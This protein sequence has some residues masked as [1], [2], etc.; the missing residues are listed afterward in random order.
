M[1]ADAYYSKYVERVFDSVTASLKIHRNRKFTVADIMFFSR[2][3]YNQYEV[4]K[5]D[6]KHYVS[7]GQV[8]FVNAGWVSTDEAT[9]TYD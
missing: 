6:W 9:P 7:R 5:L 4:K 2:W 1:S 3:Y 8:E